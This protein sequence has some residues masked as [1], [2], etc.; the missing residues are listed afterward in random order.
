MVNQKD[1]IQLER[2]YDIAHVHFKVTLQQ[3]LKYTLDS[4]EIENAYEN[5][6]E[7]SFELSSQV[8]KY[9]KQRTKI[10]QDIADRKAKKEK[11]RQNKTPIL[12]PYNQASS[13]AK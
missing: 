1:L 6:V 2:A 3:H 5:L 9:K 8:I 13:N 10:M 7:T 4:E 12:Y 11:D